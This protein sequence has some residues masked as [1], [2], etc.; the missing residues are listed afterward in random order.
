MMATDG[1][2]RKPKILL[3]TTV[4]CSYPGADTAGQMHLEYA[5]NTYVIRTP[6]PVL[7]PED[8]YLFCFEKGIDG[9]IIMSAGSDCPYIGA[10]DRLAARIPKI[11]QKM[12]DKDLSIKR[13]KLTAICSVCTKAFLK[14]INNMSAVLDELGPVD[15]QK[16]D[17]VKPPTTG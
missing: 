4:L 2:G 12:K 6:A 8:F 14:E 3:I 16:G 5:P 17:Q 13:L 11:Y 10:Y 15:M 1:N 7:F 9:I